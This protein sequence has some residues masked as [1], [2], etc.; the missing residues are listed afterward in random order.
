MAYFAYDKRFWLLDLPHRGLAVHTAVCRKGIN[1]YKSHPHYSRNVLH[2]LRE[3]ET[4]KD[5]KEDMIG[6][7]DLV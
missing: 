2:G 3:V 4:D 7:W 1:H 5:H 6:S